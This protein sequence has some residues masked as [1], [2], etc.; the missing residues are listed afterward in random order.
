MDYL[1]ELE[2]VHIIS[3]GLITL[4]E[5]SIHE[6]E[7]LEALKEVYPQRIKNSSKEDWYSIAHAALWSSL[8]LD[9]SSLLDRA[10]YRQDRNCCFLELKEVL[11]KY[12]G[13]SKRYQQVIDEVDRL[14]ENFGSIIP[15]TL[16][17]KVLA[18]SDLEQLFSW[19]EF[20]VDMNTV[21]RFLLMG[22][23]VVTN[24]LKLSVGAG[25]R[26]IDLN[27]IEQKYIASLK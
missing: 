14:L 15:D 5:N 10:K 3:C 11:I 27:Q 17:N 18:H 12:N 6:L 26:M 22:Y 13:E 25:P 7:A 20:N 24:A 4:I 19:K 8:M 23:K 1:N 2:Q 21:T 9:V 16:R